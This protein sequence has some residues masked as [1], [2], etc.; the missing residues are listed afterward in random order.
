MKSWP[1]SA[2]ALYIVGMLVGAAFALYPVVL[3][4]S[5]DPALNLTIYN[6]AA[7]HHG[8]AVGLTWWILGMVWP[9]VTSHCCSACSRARCGSRGKGTEVASVL[10]DECNLSP[11]RVIGANCYPS[12]LNGLSSNL[13]D[14]H[15]CNHSGDILMK[16][17]RNRSY[18]GAVFWPA[19]LVVLPLFAAGAEDPGEAERSTVAG[20]WRQPG[21]CGPRCAARGRLFR[22]RKR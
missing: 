17:M 11:R 14:V 18:P 4:A 19:L 9:S 7:G 6:T 20:T 8:L 2:S 13:I 16:T 21:V 12:D 5:T 15:R 3:P 1:S 22:I 10:W